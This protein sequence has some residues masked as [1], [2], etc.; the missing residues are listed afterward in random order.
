M[1][2]GQTIN[3]KVINKKEC[4]VGVRSNSTG[5]QVYVMSLVNL[6]VIKYSQ[7]KPL[8]LT[9][10]NKIM[11]VFVKVITA[12]TRHLTSMTVNHKYS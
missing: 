11:T 12:A 4:V 1:C 2:N 10:N 8:N 5:V 9:C 3:F 6:A 7:R